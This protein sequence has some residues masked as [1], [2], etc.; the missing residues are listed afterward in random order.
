MN[1]IF[2]I[3]VGTL[4]NLFI[5][6]RLFVKLFQPRLRTCRQTQKQ[7][8]RDESITRSAKR[9]TPVTECAAPQHLSDAALL[10]AA[11]LA[12]ATFMSRR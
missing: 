5:L 4:D 1:M 8:W 11:L 6:C 9:L 2:E 7:G 12:A 10:A 3:T